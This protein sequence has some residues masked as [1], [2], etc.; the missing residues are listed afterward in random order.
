M[1]F[2]DIHSHT[3]WHVDDGIQTEEEA[4]RALD[5]ALEDGFEGIVSTPHIMPGRTKKKEYE[6]IQKRQE[7]LKEMGRKTGIDIY[8]GGEIMLNSYFLPVL[9]EGW[10]PTYNGTDYM[11]VEFDVRRDYASL[12]HSM[13]PLFEMSVRDIKPVVAH[14]ERYFHKKLDTDVIDE[15]FE[16]GYVL[17]VNA[18]SLT[19][20][21]SRQSYKNAW[22]LIENGYAHAV[23]SDTHRTEGSRIPELSTA[24][25]AVVRRVGEEAA[26]LLFYENPKAILEGREVTDLPIE[27]KKKKSLFGF[28]RR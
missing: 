27:K 23:A 10:L 4:Q 21:D 8:T 3:A 14:V 20:S 15:W 25:E 6:D 19:G 2:I 26:D 24:Y 13:D 5:M 9:K 11:L 18:T 12:D 28:L 7:Q 22:Y 16:N 17:Q 1:K